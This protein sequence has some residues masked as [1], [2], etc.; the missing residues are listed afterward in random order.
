MVFLLWTQLAYSGKAITWI[1][2]ALAAGAWLGGQ[3][4]IRGGRE[5]YAFLMSALTMVGTV[6]FLFMSLFP[7]VMPSSLNESW[8]LTVVNASSTEYT[9]KIMTWVALVFTPLVLTYQ[10]WTYWVFRKRLSASHITNAE[11]GALDY[12]HEIRA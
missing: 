12:P 9:L 7:N 8:S 11:E 3:A 10:G 1:P 4:A 5:G 6:A 2:L